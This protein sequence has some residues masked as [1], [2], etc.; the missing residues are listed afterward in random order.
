MYN[1]KNVFMSKGIG[2]V[3]DISREL[4]YVPVCLMKELG[5]VSSLDK[6]L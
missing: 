3:F 6:E 1:F 2:K 5:N 4:L